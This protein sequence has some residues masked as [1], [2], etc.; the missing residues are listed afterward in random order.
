MKFDGWR[1]RSTSR[2]EESRA[3]L[4]ISCESVEIAIARRAAGYR[5]SELEKAHLADCESC[6]CEAADALNLT[7][8]VRARVDA[9]AM[10]VRSMFTRSVMARVQDEVVPVVRARRRA[11]WQRASSLAAACVLAALMTWL[12]LWSSADR[13]SRAT[14]GL[15]GSR[16][17]PSSA[18]T[19]YR[20]DGVR[21]PASANAIAAGSADRWESSFGPSD[22]A[23]A[24]NGGWLLVRAEGDGGR[25]ILSF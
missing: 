7:W 2:T 13:D 4:G 20:P 11:R 18:S 3:Q 8:P 12:G 21:S 24:H 19:G 5:L 17:E 23:A 16:V 14:A 22:E 9:D 1:K 15:V 25:E 6:R 10:S